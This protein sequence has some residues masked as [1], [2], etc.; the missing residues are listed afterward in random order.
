[1]K[2][3][4]NYKINLNYSIKYLPKLQLATLQ[5]T[6]IYGNVNINNIK[7]Y[8]VIHFWRPNF[9][10]LSTFIKFYYIFS[11]SFVYIKNPA[12]GRQGISRPM[13]IVAPMP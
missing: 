1:M 5:W 8:F 12:Y 2:K 4:K 13:Q 6:S 10:P 9:L 7:K 3:Q 11:F